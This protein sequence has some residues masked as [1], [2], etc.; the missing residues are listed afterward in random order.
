[1]TPKQKQFCLYCFWI[2]GDNHPKEPGVIPAP[3]H[4]DQPLRE[5]V[6]GETKRAE[7]LQR[8]ESRTEEMGKPQKTVFVSFTVL[9]R[10]LSSHCHCP[11]HPHLTQTHT[12]VIRV[13]QSQSCHTPGQELTGCYLH[14]TGYSQALTGW[15]P[16]ISAIFPYLQPQE[17]A[18]LA[19]CLQFSL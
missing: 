16:A 15:N 3:S 14:P 4:L 8:Q 11:P 13:T 17:A 9:P 7:E 5:G 18:T 6:V 1:M 12:E 19:G 2:L 10:P